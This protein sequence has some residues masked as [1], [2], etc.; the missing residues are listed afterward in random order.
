M[1]EAT[2][3]VVQRWPLRV[4]RR[5]KWGECDP[6][7]VVYTARF[8]DYVISAYELLMRQLLDGPL[9]QIK[10]RFGFGTPMKALSLVFSASLRPD[11]EFDMTVY[12]AALRNRTFDIRVDA[13]DLEG[14]PFFQATLTPITIPRGQRTHSIELPSMLRERLVHYQERCKE[15]AETDRA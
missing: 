5:V 2:E 11:E 1:L 3:Q 12:V 14:R 7:G 4:R 13:C 8:S 15:A 9:Q 10:D 6:A